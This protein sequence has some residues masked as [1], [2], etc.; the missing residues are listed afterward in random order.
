[1]DVCSIVGILALS[2]AVG[3]FAALT[4]LQ[5]VLFAMTRNR[6][7]ACA[8]RQPSVLFDELVQEFAPR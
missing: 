5:L 7:S 4:V 8:E 1:M 3:L 2:V 6:T